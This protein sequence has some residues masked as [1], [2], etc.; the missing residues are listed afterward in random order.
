MPA[1]GTTQVWHKFTGHLTECR[2]LWQTP[3]RSSRRQMD[4]W[5][6][7]VFTAPQVVWRAVFLTTR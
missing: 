6:Q 5:Y 3:G 4:S 2:E 7:C 1:L